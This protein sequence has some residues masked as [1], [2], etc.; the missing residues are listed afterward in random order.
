MRRLLI[1][2]WSEGVDDVTTTRFSLT[3][4]ENL[5]WLLFV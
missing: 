5:Q 3:G 2:L 1:H 4:G